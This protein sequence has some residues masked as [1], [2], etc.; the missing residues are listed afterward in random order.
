MSALFERERELAEL[1]AMVVEVCAGGGRLAVVEAAAG[2]GK[3]RLLLAARDRG[4][5]AGMRVLAARATELERDFPFALARQ[6]FEPALAALAAPARAVLFEGAAGSARSAVEATDPDAPPAE[7]AADTFA[8][9][10]GLY[11]LT[12]AFA[13][14]QP[15]LLAVDDAHWSDAASLDFLGFLLPRLEELPVLLVVACRRDEPGAERSLARIATDSLARRLTPH[16][17]SPRATTALLADELE[18][19]PEEAFAAACHEVSGG[20][21]FLLGELARTLAAERIDPAVAQASH[22][23]ELAPE[24]VTR[25][26]LVRLA[27]LSREAQAVARAVVVLG[28][29]ADGLLTAELAGLDEAVAARAADELRAAAILDR[30]ATLRFV[31]PLVRTALDVE[32]PAGERAA[33]HVRAVELLRARGASPQQLAAHLVATDARG[34]RETV[35]TLLEAGRAALSSGAPRSAIAYLTRALHEPAPEDLRVVILNSLMIAGIRA[36]D[37]TLFAALLPEVLAEMERNPSLRLRWGVKV[38]VWM[39]LNGRVDGAAPLLE[40]AIEVANAEGD[41]EHAFRLEAQL[42][43]VTPRTLLATRAQLARYSAGIPPDSPCGRLLAAY[44]SEWHAFDGTALD[45]TEAA[46]RA[47]AHDGRIFVEQPEFFAPGRPVLALLLADEVRLADRAVKRALAMARQRGATPELV[48]S[49]W[50]SSG[51]AWARGDL[52]AADA[53]MRQALEVARLGKLRYALLPL[54]ATLTSLLVA[55][56]E[57]AAAEAEVEASGMSGG[58]PNAFVFVLWLFARGQLRFAQGRFEEA[59]ADFETL[60][61]FAVGWGVIGAPAPPVYICVARV[62]TAL[63]DRERARTLADAALTRARRWG[64]PVLVASALRVQAATLDGSARI[65]ALEEAVAMLDRSPARLARAEALTELGAALRRARRRVDARP[66]LREALELARRCGAA[67]LARRAHDEL[68]ATGERVR[69]YTP[70][71]VESLT[72]SERRVAELA[73]SGMTNLQIAQTRF[74]TVKTIETHLSSVYDKLGIRSRR[75]LP[76]ALGEPAKSGV[77]PD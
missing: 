1:D 68:A 74:L 46:R 15:L 11:W 66:P 70:I 26:V 6:L 28:D 12:A 32:L 55:R 75:Q 17:L 64:A 30:D 40:R 53:D 23:R 65:T 71:G 38:T 63:D 3:T 5:A 34:A 67:S 18:H 50:M 4:R 60:E 42:S 19:E 51:V 22:V 58:M 24:R 73:A 76:A 27:R 37:R 49:W 52:P 59:A 48:A 39:I 13:A 29:G 56:G 72:P 10:H 25:T 41:V 77:A 8:V 36:P 21:P 33:A 69:R 43:L 62:A 2:L 14:Q 7:P 54:R 35:E 57:L 20:N 45:A 31:H 9:L 47:L 44:E 61:R 16:P